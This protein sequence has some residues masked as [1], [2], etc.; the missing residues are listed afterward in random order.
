VNSQ[1]VQVAQFEIPAD[2]L[3]TVRTRAQAGASAELES[4]LY[5]REN[6]LGELKH[7]QLMQAQAQYAKAM[8]ISAATLRR[9]LWQIKA[10]S[11]DDLYRWLDAGISFEHLET[12]S[13]YADV[14]HKTPKRLLDECISLGDAAGKIMTVE[15]LTSHAVGEREDRPEAYQA[16]NLISR[17]LNIP[18]KMKWDDEKLSRWNDWIKLGK[19]FFG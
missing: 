19:E 7:G 2:V 14:A 10:Y 18:Q 5:F 17:L 8:M 12:A 1:S 13:Q 6:F 9:K 15:N 16:I 4:L 11:P 3:A